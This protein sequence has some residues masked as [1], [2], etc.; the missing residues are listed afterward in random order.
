MDL[1]SDLIPGSLQLHL[2]RT[3]YFDTTERLL[4]DLI[5]LDTSDAAMWAPVLDAAQGH[6]ERVSLLV[7]QLPA[8]YLLE[9]LRRLDG[10]RRLSD[11]LREDLRPAY[12]ALRFVLD[13]ATHTPAILHLPPRISE[14]LRSPTLP[15]MDLHRALKEIEAALRAWV[16]QGLGRG[17]GFRVALRQALDQLR[18]KCER[19]NHSNLFL[20]A[21]AQLQQVLPRIQNGGGMRTQLL[22]RLI[23]PILI[24]EGLA[25]HYRQQSF[26]RMVDQILSGPAEATISPERFLK[27]YTGIKAEHYA[28][29]FSPRIP[30]TQADL[31]MLLWRIYQMED[32]ET[33]DELTLLDKLCSNPPT[34]TAVFGPRGSGKSHLRVA[35]HRTLCQ[36][37]DEFVL[38]I[39]GLPTPE[40]LPR[41]LAEAFVET[42]GPA[43]LIRCGR[44]EQISA[45]IEGDAG[46]KSRFDSLRQ[47]MHMRANGQ[48]PPVAAEPGDEALW[49]AALADLTL[50]TSRIVEIAT[51]LEIRAL[52]VLVDSVPCDPRRLLPL[53][54]QCWREE[55]CRFAFKLFMDQALQEQFV[56]LCQSTGTDMHMHTLKPWRPEPLINL[57]G[58]RIQG[59]SSDTQ[60]KDHTLY[61]LCR[62]AGDNTPLLELARAADG[63]PGPFLS[64]LKDLVEFHCRGAKNV[65]D[66]IQSATITAFLQARGQAP[67]QSG[68][69]YS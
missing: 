40:E 57:V 14:Q 4:A 19:S 37:R 24:L 60:V 64:L 2:K 27:R 47:S 8:T 9:G 49:Q 13:V 52:Y 18:V 51:S 54:Q 28:T 21:R 66:L 16:D 62:L 6:D 29:F 26:A 58:D 7:G 30:S 31:R 12:E 10:D 25:W 69:Q 46:L 67:P 38:E 17:S 65:D 48:C 34:S 22:D 39:D 20:A 50:L 23:V 3:P 61:D 41:M 68:A 36:D 55:G 32:T 45:R 15:L 33:S 63:F 43:G 11:D 5:R 56:T 44:R 42:L 1:I 53:F 59:F 35:V